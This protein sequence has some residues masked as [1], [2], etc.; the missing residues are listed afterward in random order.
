MRADAQRAKI[1]PREIDQR[2]PHLQGRQVQKRTRASAIGV[3]LQAAVDA[4]QRLL[5]QIVGP[6][7]RLSGLAC[8]IARANVRSRSSA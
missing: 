7:P 8:S 3:P 2:L 1:M 5:D 4:H 6:L